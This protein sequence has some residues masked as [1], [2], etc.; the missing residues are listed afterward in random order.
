MEALILDPGALRK[1]Y[2]DSITT[3]H[4]NVVYRKNVDESMAAESCFICTE[5]LQI[6]DEAVTLRCEC[7]YWAHEACLA[8]AAFETSC[9][10][11]CRT[12]M[13]SLDEDVEMCYD[14]I[15]HTSGKQPW[16]SEEYKVCITWGSVGICYTYLN[17][18]VQSVFTFWPIR[19]TTEDIVLATAAGKGD[20]T[21]VRD[22]LE[23]GVQPSPRCIFDSTPLL[24]AAEGGH[25]EIIHLLIKH[26]ASVAE[27]DRYQR[28]A[29]YWASKGGHQKTVAELLSH[30]A[31]LSGVHKQ[32]QTLL[33]LAVMS[34]STETVA[35]FV[36]KGSGL[37][38]R[39]H[40]GKSPLHVAVDRRD[41]ETVSLLV[42][43]GA[44]VSPI[45]RCGCTPLHYAAQR[46]Y[47]RVTKILID[48]GADVTFRDM[49][50]RTARELAVEKNAKHALEHLDGE[51]LTGF[52]FFQGD[53]IEL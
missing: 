9:C 37:S 35:L 39:D 52:R 34:R 31:D 3:L 5:G 30:G 51:E 48:G 12:S 11:T 8:K 43:R 29:L 16:Q 25:H 42:G 1:A 20:L 2:R 38:A 44:E 24:E 49:T 6:G 41:K 33:H 26:G 15:N 28:S 50:G 7:P 18:I 45:D 32:G 27:Q 23:K 40:E 13:A 47:G 46:N 19:Q 21:K 10:P 14:I 53:F 17:R 4:N 22:L 36:D